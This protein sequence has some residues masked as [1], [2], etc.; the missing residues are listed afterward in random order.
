MELKKYFFIT[1]AALLFTNSVQADRD[2]V[3]IKPSEINGL[4]P[5]AGRKISQFLVRGRRA[6]LHV[7]GSRLVVSDVIGAPQTVVIDARGVANFNGFEVSSKQGFFNF[8]VYYVHQAHQ[9]D[10]YF[11]NPDG[12][13]AEDN[14]LNSLPPGSPVAIGD[15][16][17][18]IFSKEF[19]RKSNE[20]NEIQLEWND[21]IGN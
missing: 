16:M 7:N 17:G 13:V 15:I 5:Y 18:D 1:I 6:S 8:V 11:K 10:V 3:Q 20:V 9:N 21:L 12:S 14:R 19:L 2:N 4:K